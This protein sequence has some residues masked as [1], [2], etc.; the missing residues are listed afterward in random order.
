[1]LGGG[2]ELP[3]PIPKMPVLKILDFDTF[4]KD[5]G[6]VFLEIWNTYSWVSVIHVKKTV[7]DNWVGLNSSALSLLLY[8]KVREADDH[9]LNG[10]NKVVLD[11]R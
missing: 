2:A 5:R 8:V 6:I 11:L 7:T 1:M 10:E 3:L 9:H 4:W